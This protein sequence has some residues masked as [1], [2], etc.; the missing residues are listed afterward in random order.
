MMTIAGTARAPRD[1]GKQGGCPVLEGRVG[2]VEGRLEGDDRGVAPN[3]LTMQKAETIRVCG[4][5]EAYFRGLLV[6][7]HALS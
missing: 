5:T 1:A 2:S 3:L 4:W 7:S 6:R